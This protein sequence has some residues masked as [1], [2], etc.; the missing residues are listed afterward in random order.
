[1]HCKLMMFWE[2]VSQCE[3]PCPIVKSQKDCSANKIDPL[4]S[5]ICLLLPRFT[6]MVVTDTY[7]FNLA[8]DLVC[9]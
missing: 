3:V 2:C 7:D 4:D 5:S 8:P 6:A 1:M 9:L